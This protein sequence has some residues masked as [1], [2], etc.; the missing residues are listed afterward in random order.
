MNFAFNSLHDFVMM[1]HHG[2]YVWS[3]WLV[4]LLSVIYLVMQ[5]RY[6]RKS[7]F[8]AE[9]VNIQLQKARSAR[10]KHESLK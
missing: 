10:L 7:F 6:A 5:S 4:A 9:Q 1:G 3:A 2:V 8:R